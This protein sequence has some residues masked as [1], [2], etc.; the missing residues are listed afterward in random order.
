MSTV[1]ALRASWRMVMSVGL[2]AGNAMTS[3][4]GRAGK[5]CAR[6]PRL[7]PARLAAASWTRWRRRILSPE[8]FAD[9]NAYWNASAASAKAGASNVRDS[10]Q[11]EG[12]D[13]LRI[14][15]LPLTVMVCPVPCVEVS[16]APV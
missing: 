12:L 9:G 11:P 3:F 8:V 14:G 2:P 10:Q 5:A 4:T 15:M 7:A 16:T 1:P 6:A 13:S